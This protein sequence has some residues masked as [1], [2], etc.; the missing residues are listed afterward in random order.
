MKHPVI[1][2]LILAG[3]SGTRFWPLSRRSRPKQLLALAGTKPLI[4]ETVQRLRGVARLSSLSIACGSAHARQIR[5]LVPGLRADQLL[6]EPVARNTAPAIGWAALHVLK[7]DPQGVMVV[8]PS[9]HHV[10]DPRRFRELLVRAAHL[11][12]DGTLYTLGIPPTGPETGYGYL[13]LGAELP[14]G[15]R[16]VKAF[17]EKPSL[18]KARKY[19]ASGRYLWN[20]GIFVFRADAI[21]AEIRRLLPELAALLDQIAAVVG[22]RREREVVAR[23]FPRA[24]NVSIDYG[25]MEKAK[26][27]ATLPADVGWSDLGSFG[28]LSEVKPSDAQG[29]VTDGVCVAI[30]SERSI[31]LAHD[32]PIVLLGVK[33]LIVVDAGDVVLVAPR[34]RD[35]DVRLVVAEIA[36]R[37]LDHLL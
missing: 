35:Q 27:V 7:R 11:C 33:D 18:P 23:L 1:Y 8:L 28:A 22:T 29:N 2:P 36:R 3:G 10:R 21:L 14:G 15:A 20:G 37:R 32:R 25:I 13:Q 16:A 34:D 17:V 24:P 19:V 12:A 6:I 31:A 9:D 4:V 5:R 30:D 26:R